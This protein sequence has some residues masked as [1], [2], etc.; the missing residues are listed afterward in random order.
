MNTIDKIA[1]SLIKEDEG[2]RDYVYADSKGN[3]TCGWGHKI[4][5]GTKVRYIISCIFFKDDYSKAKKSVLKILQIFNLALNEVRIAV[6]ISLAFNMGIGNYNKKTGLLGF[7]KM[8]KA[9]QDHDFELASEELKDSKWYKDVGQNR[10]DRLIDML[11]Y[12]NL[13]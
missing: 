11:R 1:K 6:L 8:F 3:L 2:Y 13:S 9:L 12:G 7:R 4:A 5:L 10:A